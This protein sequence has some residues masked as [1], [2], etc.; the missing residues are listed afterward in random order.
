MISDP[1]LKRSQTEQNSAQSRGVQI[2][3]RFRDLIE[4]TSC[5]IWEVDDSLRYVYAS[6]K[7]FDLLGYTPEEL[8]GRTPFDFMPALEAV[9]MRGE[10]Q[11]LLQHPRP[12][13]ALEN[14]N[15]CKDGAPRV[16]ET[17][18]IPILDAD[19]HLSGL[20]GIDRDITERKMAE[21]A[22]QS[23]L[24]R[25]AQEK[26]RSEA[27]ISAIGEGLIIV[28]RQFKVLYQNRILQELAGDP[29]EDHCYVLY[30]GREKLCDNCPVAR[31]FQDGEIHTIEKAA[32]K[33]GALVYREITASPL[34]DESG[35]IIAGI[36]LV[37][38]ITERKRAEL[39]LQ[40]SERQMK[41]VQRIANLGSW[42]LDH[43]TDKLV[44]SDETYRILGWQPQEIPASYEAF[45]EVV[46][47]EDRELVASR[48]AE[49]VRSASEGYEIGHRILRK[50]GGE[51]RYIHQKCEHIKDETGKVIRSYGM[52]HDITPHKEA[53]ERISV[54][55]ADLSARACE[56]ERAN[57]DLEAFSYTVSHDLRGP[58]TNINSYCQ[59]IAELAADK[60]D[61]QCSGFLNS[62]F[63][64][65]RSMDGLIT[66]LLNLSRFNH[67]K[68][69]S[70][71]V[72]LS[73]MART[74]AAEL[75]IRE[76]E[77]RVTFEIGEGI[78]VPGDERLLRVVLANLMG[79][80]WKFSARRDDPV[81]RFGV[82]QSPVGPIYYVSDNGIG[83]KMS[84]S[85]KIFAVFQRLH[86][87]EEFEGFGIGLTTVHRIIDRHHGRIWAE[88]EP[89]KGA[90]FSFTLNEKPAEAGTG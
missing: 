36:E 30:G 51:L 73:E 17:S 88:G 14:V 7:A 54:L 63:R 49:S 24:V 86:R 31:T 46:H 41:E 37:R 85:D 80:A 29:F 5:R 79:N 1:R 25:S 47:P 32:L 53:Q 83:F 34:R 71:R 57:K 23:A 43:L 45:L 58:L 15:L 82:R 68:L 89:G 42:Q 81:I 18:G 78:I 16:L 62:V 22:L 21:L 87:S 50:S 10:F 65:V 74:I 72:N 27:I 2:E 39:A 69:K 84:Q 20:R 59:A 11:E 8:L 3:Q 76:P 60:L 44:W 61:S 26:A 6:A 70:R 64:E 67:I 9:R 28:D 55:N 12:F 33:D 40:E 13:K 77:R 66:S 19:G 52:I 75:Q 38:D 48:Y 56:L 35:E 4:N 90:K